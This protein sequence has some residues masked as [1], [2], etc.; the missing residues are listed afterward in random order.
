MKTNLTKKMIDAIILPQSGQVL[1]Y[2]T[3]LQG[4]GLR[5]TKT[6][7]TYFAEGYLLGKQKRV[8]IGKHGI[9]TPEQGRTEARQILA[10][11]AR[12]EDPSLKKTVATT[13]E[14]AYADMIAQRTGGQ[15]EQLK[16]KTVEGYDWL[17]KT[18]LSDYKSNK[19]S[20]FSEAKVRSI[21]AKLTA[22]SGPYVANNA[23]RLIRNIFNYSIW[24]YSE[25]K[26]VSNPVDCMEK[27]RLWNPETRR[28][29]HIAS[30]DLPEWISKAESL[31]GIQ[32]GAMLMMLFLGL[33]K[34][35][36]YCM[37]KAEIDAENRFVGY[38]RA[39]SDDF[40]QSNS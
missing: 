30:D 19:L 40:S 32:R 35:E 17:M 6:A 39:C 36:V 9:F 14:S 8:T 2:D 25:L 29:R 27:L 38:L 16:P 10:K 4:F 1:Y 3:T 22:D 7:K 31:D 20:S 21:H 24:A 12:G 13:L 37:K 34:D 15:G 23:L 11:L 5:A 26:G 18:P 33:R 28:K